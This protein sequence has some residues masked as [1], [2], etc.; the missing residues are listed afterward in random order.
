MR[1]N[2][3]S[4]A[5]SRGEEET[6][7]RLGLASKSLACSVTAV[8]HLVRSR[9]LPPNCFSPSPVASF[10]ADEAPVVGCCLLYFIMC[11]LVS[12]P[13]PRSLFGCVTG[14]LFLRGGGRGHAKLKA[15][16]SR[17][18]VGSLAPLRGGCVQ[19][20][21]GLRAV[22]PRRLRGTFFG[23]PLGFLFNAR[24]SFPGGGRDGR[25]LR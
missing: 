2:K 19:L 11:R 9:P 18:P 5:T 22:Q 4:C 10:S 21:E 16:V 17:L 15:M 3:P 20:F 6:G 25:T 12:L 8:V 23:P 24:I 1:S 14:V 13:F 7:R